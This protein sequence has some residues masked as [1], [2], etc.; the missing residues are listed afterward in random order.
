MGMKSRVKGK[1]GEREIAA[2]VRDLTGWEV[3]RKVR[4]LDGESD[5]EG[6]P[7]WCVEV[8]RHATATRGDIAGWWKQAVD[9]AQAEDAMPILFF[10][11]D[12]DEWRA[13][14]PSQIEHGDALTAYEWTVEGSI[15][16]WAYI[17][18]EMVGEALAALKGE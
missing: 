18:R 1:V 5:L 15:E 16:A 3:R 9:Q 12:R 6:V 2:I 10:R 14:W 17:A 13:V 4:Q 8:K 11:K 7:G